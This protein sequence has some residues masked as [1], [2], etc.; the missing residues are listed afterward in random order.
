MRT[1]GFGGEVVAQVAESGIQWLSRPRRITAVDSR[2]PAAPVLAAAV[3]PDADG[4]A[5]S[6]R[7]SAAAR[8]PATVS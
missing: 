2:I 1:G 7:E 5:A 6:L 4:I 3:L 8:V